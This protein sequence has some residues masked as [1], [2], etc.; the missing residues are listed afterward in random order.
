MK[1]RTFSLAE[2]RALLPQVKEL[3]QRA[4]EA[5]GEIVR[6]RPELWPV[7]SKAASNGGSR[8]A[9]EVLIHFKQLESGIKGIMALGVLVKDVDHGLVDFVGM[10]EGRE[11]YL[12]W[13]H[14]EDDI[15][16]WHDVNQGFG[17][18]QPIDRFIE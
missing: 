8:E 10:R 7:L 14:G 16:F 9:G 11:V 15:R 17:G 1:A 13:K 6:L 5:R 18:R 4:Q 3:M 2:A 12:C